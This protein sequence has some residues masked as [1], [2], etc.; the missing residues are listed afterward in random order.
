MLKSGSK[1]AIVS[2][3][4]G[5]PSIFPHIYENGLKVLKE[6]FN[7]QIVEFP[8][9]KMAAQEVYENPQLRARDL[10]N[11]FADKSI[12]GIISTIGG[13]DSVRILKYLKTDL[14]LEN[15]KFIMGFSDSTTFLS[16]LNTLGLVTFYGPSIM[17]GFSQLLN[18]PEAIAEYMN[19][20]KKTIDFNI[21]PFS[22]YCHKYKQWSEIKNTGLVDKI[23]ENS[24]GHFW[25]NKGS[26][27]NGAIWGGCIEVLCDIN[28]T[29]F[30]P[31]NGFWKG[32]VLFIE[33]SEEKP[34][35]EQV[36]YWLRNYGIQGILNQLS[37]LLIARPK[38]YSEEEII[39]LSEIVKKIVIKEFDCH[40]LNI[41]M[42]LD[43]GHTDPR[44]I[45]PLGINFE[46]DPYNESITI[47]ENAFC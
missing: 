8:T 33:T 43:I 46:I 21:Y 3:S 19:F 4:W 36:G 16:Y 17:A 9:S 13:N 20:F 1:I 34:K 41:V 44:H 5:G 24:N 22:T 26:V 47:K 12:D 10:N 15:P 23:Y 39:Q 6:Q 40:Q 37:G 38:D 31:K 32:K 18:F 25:L 14:I 7:F 45:L 11:A 27:S 29:D 42:N 30:W 35:P 28:G 2:P